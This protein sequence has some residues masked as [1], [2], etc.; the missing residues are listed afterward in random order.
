LYSI[1][2]LLIATEKFGGAEKDKYLFYMSNT[3]WHK[4][5]NGSKSKIAFY[6]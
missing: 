1:F 2:T 6:D 4:Y 3:F 5:A